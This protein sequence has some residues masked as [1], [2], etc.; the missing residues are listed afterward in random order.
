MCL[1]PRAKS[2]PLH[3]KSRS[4]EGGLYYWVMPEICPPRASVMIQSHNLLD[5]ILKPNPK[6]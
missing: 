2:L 3:E 1:H 5:G 4:L 6:T